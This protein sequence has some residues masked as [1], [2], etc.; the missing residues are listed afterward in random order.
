MPTEDSS[1]PGGTREVPLAAWRSVDWRFLLPSMRLSRVG[2][3]GTVSQDERHVLAELGTEVLSCPG[4]EPKVDVLVTDF[5]SADSWGAV[6]SLGVTQEDVLILGRVSRLRASVGSRIARHSLWRIR[7]RLDAH[8]LVVDAVFWHAP[9]RERCSYIVAIDDRRGVADML[10]RYHGVR[11]GRLKSLVARLLNAAGC[12]ALI[13]P[14]LTVVARPRRTRENSTDDHGTPALAPTVEVG[15]TASIRY[16]SRLLV[17]PWFEASRHVLCLYMD[18]HGSLAAVAKMPRRPGDVDG[19]RHEADVL[20][21]L[22][23]TEA[24]AGHLPEVLQLS[25]GAQPFLLETALRGRSADPGT[26]RARGD[27]IIEAGLD[28]LAR[29][30]TTGSTATDATWFTRL[31]E[32]PLADVAARVALPSMPVLVQETL[33]RLEPLRQWSFPL[34]AE[35]GDLSHP[36][37]ILDKGGRLLAIDWE[38]SNLPGIPGHDLFFLLQYVAEARH[39]TFERVGQLAAFDQAFVGATGWASPWVRRY[40]AGLGL[41]AEMLPALLLATWARSSAGLAT[42][43]AP[44]E[45]GIL[46]PGNLSHKSD[47]LA[48]AFAEDRDHALWNHALKRFNDLLS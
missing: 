36:N 29:L 11:F 8:G 47:T 38:R 35:H 9:N 42:R 5:D 40:A 34:V 2:Y 45:G 6:S 3:V 25:M 19:I 27:G 4:G 31:I 14:D 39:D 22:A 24:L 37:L 33:A 16:P 15:P 21:T 26:V 46:V 44:P 32:E 10:K 48:V 17:T 23:R 30:P 28:F 1:R 13:A 7:R 43:V 20:R 41:S 18:R 12:V